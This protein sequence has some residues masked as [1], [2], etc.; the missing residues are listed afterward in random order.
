LTPAEYETAAL[1]AGI[2][3]LAE[4]GTMLIADAPAIFMDPDALIEA[5]EHYSPRSRTRIRPSEP[6]ASDQD[7]DP[8][9]AMEAAHATARRHRRLALEALLAGGTDVDLTPHM[10]ADWSAAV[11]ILV[12]ALAL[13]TDPKEPF[14]LELSEWL[15]VDSEA[16]V[17]YLHPARLTRADPVASQVLDESISADVARPG[18]SLG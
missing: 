9:A 1:T 4:T 8:L 10:Q 15:L 13:S 3:Q 18:V 16:R 14:L 6:A 7:H 17:T 12:D 2:D 11:Q 5:V